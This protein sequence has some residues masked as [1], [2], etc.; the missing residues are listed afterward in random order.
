MIFQEGVNILRIEPVFLAEN[1]K[2]ESPWTLS[3]LFQ[4][5]Y[6]LRFTRKPNLSKRVHLKWSSI[7]MIKSNF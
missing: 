3:F 5:Y 4:L 7:M 2:T 1:K 6:Y